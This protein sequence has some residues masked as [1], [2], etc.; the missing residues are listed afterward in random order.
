MEN[1]FDP[2]MNVLRVELLKDIYN[3]NGIS[4]AELN[5]ADLF[6]YSKNSTFF[7][8]LN[9]VLNTSYLDA[10]IVL[11]DEQMECLSILEETNLFLSAPTSFGK[12]FV[13]MEYIARKNQLLNNIIFVVPTISL[14]NEL[15]KKC[16]EYFRD[17]YILITSD[18]ELEQYAGEAKKIMIVVPERI[19]TR[20]FK[21]YIKN[22]NIDLLVYDEIYKLKY[23]KSERDTNDRIIK[24]NYIYR[25]LIDKASKIV[26]L[27]PFIKNVNFEKSNIEI[28]KYITNLN[29]VYNEIDFEIIILVYWNIQEKKSSYISNLLI[30]LGDFLVVMN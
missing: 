2:N 16:F 25:Y 5:L 30:V 22:N 7:A 9:R 3:G 15:R 23:D 12:T 19:S 27:G 26:L 29:L 8:R 24:M 10:S 4:E 21:K 6:I 11:T 1:K 14:M 13:A 28:K 18:A 17:E 20:K